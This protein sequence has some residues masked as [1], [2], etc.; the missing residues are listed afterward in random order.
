MLVS[1]GPEVLFQIGANAYPV[2]AST[3]NRLRPN[4]TRQKTDWRPNATL[5]PVSERMSTLFHR[6][7]SSQSASSKR[8]RCPKS[9]HCAHQLH[10]SGVHQGIRLET[11]CFTAIDR[12]H[13]NPSGTNNPSVL[14]NKLNCSDVSPFEGYTQTDVFPRLRAQLV[15]ARR[16]PLHPRRPQRS[17]CAR[18]KI[19]ESGRR[20]DVA[21]HPPMEQSVS[22][23]SSPR[24]SAAHF[25]TTCVWLTA[26]IR[27]GP[28]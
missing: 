11:A 3:K 13:H 5:D 27:Q 8:G 9:T 12:V 16:A 24:V 15:A 17:S 23:W 1:T 6:R 10:A 28:V 26:T 14:P 2:L 25:R 4:A 18:R 20:R 21:C 22:S 7:S 19:A